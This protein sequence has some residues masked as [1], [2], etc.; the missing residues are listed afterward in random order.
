M[1]ELDIGWCPP[2]LF[3]PGDTAA[4]PAVA[5]REVSEDG[6]SSA[7]SANRAAN[8]AST[9][10]QSAAVSVFLAAM[11]IWAQAVEVDPHLDA[12]CQGQSSEYG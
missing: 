12:K 5:S 9:T 1:P 4:C 10:V 2:S 8:A 11:A 3:V 7:N 6:P